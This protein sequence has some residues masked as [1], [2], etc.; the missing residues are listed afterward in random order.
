MV[1]AIL[2]IK[3]HPPRGKELVQALRTL[4]RAARAEKGFIACQLYSETD[5]TN[6]ICYE[7]AWRDPK[8]LDDQV[9]SARYT[10]LLTLMEAAAEP[11]SLEFHF[12]A[13]TRGLEYVAALRGET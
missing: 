9:R 11:P 5:N 1:L 3:S 8:A 6:S 4:M 13:E 12:V 7:E 2:R 10:H